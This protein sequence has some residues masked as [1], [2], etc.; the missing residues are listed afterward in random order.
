[1]VSAFVLRAYQRVELFADSVVLG[2]ILGAAPEPRLDGTDGGSVRVQGDRCRHDFHVR[3]VTLK[4]GQGVLIRGEES[5]DVRTCGDILVAE[6]QHSGVEGF[7]QTVPEQ[8]VASFD[9]AQR[10]TACTETGRAHV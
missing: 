2:A 5:V 1:M 4:S 7:G 9:R 3:K 8:G 6:F 10:V